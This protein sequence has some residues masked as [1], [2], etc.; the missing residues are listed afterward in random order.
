[1]NADISARLRA[2]RDEIGLDQR[3]LADRLGVSQAVIS[4]AENGRREVSK[5]LTQK[6][7]FRFGLNPDW[8]LNGDDPKYLPLQTQH[9][10]YRSA[11]VA[12][13]DTQ[14]PAHGD[15]ALDGQEFQLIRRFDAIASAGTGAL[16]QSDHV[17]DNIAVT[18]A[19]LLRQG[20]NGDLCGLVEV[21][22]DS[23][24]PFIRDGDLALVHFAELEVQDG[25]VYAFS[26]RGELFIKRLVRI[27]NGWLITSD[28]PA[29]SPVA[30][31]GTDEF[32]MRI[33]GRVR[34]VMSRF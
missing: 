20:L 21:K 13:P 19:W 30:L 2:F 27:A 12:A 22:G 33:H 32:E 34:A 24:S 29:H 26:L 10:Q 7:S 8:L 11:V 17:I 9:H 1:M 25:R 16:V 14:R 5:G 28:N 23:M 3:S 18:R 31:T 6:L 15:V 4:H